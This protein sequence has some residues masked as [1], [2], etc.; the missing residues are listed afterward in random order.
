MK[1]PL[2]VGHF[3]TTVR[4]FRPKVTKPINLDRVRSIL[5][6]HCDKDADGMPIAAGLTQEIARP[7]VAGE[8]LG[9]IGHE[10]VHFKAGYLICPWLSAGI[11][12]E[13]AKFVS[14]L[15]STLGVQIFEPG[16]A[17]YYS[18]EMLIEAEREFY[19]GK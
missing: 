2:F 7:A 3:D 10:D 17:R 18:P 6:A 16:D 14:Q 8:W 19:R 11:N 1:H 5:L 15:H 4:S 12:A 13:S 9:R